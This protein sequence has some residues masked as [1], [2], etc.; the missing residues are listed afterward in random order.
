MIQMVVRWLSL[1]YCFSSCVCYNIRWTLKF[2]AF[3]DYIDIFMNSCD[4]PF[5]DNVV[6]SAQCR[7]GLVDDWWKV[8]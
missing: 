2:Q 3:G 5:G 8:S 1:P 4:F 6:R 7:G